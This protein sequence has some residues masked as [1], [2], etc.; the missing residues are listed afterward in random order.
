MIKNSPPKISVIIPIF[1]AGKYL[2]EC[3]DSVLSQTLEDIEVLCVDDGS[4]DQSLAILREYKSRNARLKIINQHNSG[5][6]PARNRAMK[7]AKGEF[8]AFI[9]A[10]DFYP[11]LASLEKLY[12]AAKNHRVK[13]AGGSFSDYDSK[14]KK[15]NTKYDWLGATGYVF[16]R[17]ERMSYRNYQFDYGWTRFIYDREMLAEHNLWQADSRWGEDPTFFIQ[18]MLAA[19]SFYAIPDVTYC[20]RQFHKTNN[21]TVEWA[22]I[23]LK[24]F[25]NNLRIAE[26]NN[27]EKLKKLTLYRIEWAIRETS[28]KKIHAL[29]EENRRLENEAKQ[30]ETILKNELAKLEQSKAYRIGTAIAQPVRM[31][32]SIFKKP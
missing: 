9:D 29:E 12:D 22:T 27:L 7:Q 25:Y 30:R 10:D 13:I 4:T 8:L 2:P 6:G 3:L 26:E 5:P 21:F 14:S 17:A 23:A 31:F 28:K 16:K 1:N 20:Y 32:K 24:N 18:A 19:G 11:D 15:I